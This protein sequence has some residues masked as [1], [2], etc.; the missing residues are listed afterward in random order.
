MSP[1][2][3][4]RRAGAVP[5]QVQ[6]GILTQLQNA[7]AQLAA[8]GGT[9]WGQRQM[10]GD[11]K[12][13]VRLLEEQARELAVPHRWIEFVKQQGSAGLF[14]NARQQLPAGAAEAR[15]QQLQ[16]LHTE[17]DH[18]YEMAALQ[19]AYRDHVGG[20]TS[21][22]AGRFD[23]LQQLQWWRIVMVARGLNITATE[24]GNHWSADPQ[25][26][27]ALLDSMRSLPAAQLTRRWHDYTTATALGNARMRFHALQLVGLDPTATPAPP[28]PEQLKHTAEQLWHA[29]D[30]QHPPATA[31]ESSEPG[32]EIAD[33]ITAAT[34]TETDSSAP[35]STATDT[36]SELR[37]EVH[38]QIEAEP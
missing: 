28:E 3:E 7:T 15:D 20:L 21:T 8:T 27:T 23:E 1:R 24:I 10:V 19:A 5:T 31:A 18:L 38:V 13:T 22:R 30:G 33:A 25:R 36:S 14:W 32:I 29:P 37:A 17:V 35:E 6:A 11:L 2:A 12:A 34:T 9:A 26:W 4:D 16:R